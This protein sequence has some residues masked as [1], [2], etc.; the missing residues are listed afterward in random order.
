MTCL[1]DYRISLLHL[2]CL[3]WYVGS[4]PG[5]Q[6]DWNGIWSPGMYL[7]IWLAHLDLE[8]CILFI[9]SIQ[10][11]SSRCMDLLLWLSLP[12]HMYYS[13]KILAAAK[14][15]KPFFF[16]PN[17]VC[18]LVS[19]FG[20]NWS[21]TEVLLLTSKSY[22]LTICLNILQKEIWMLLLVKTQLKAA[23]R[24]IIIKFS[25]LLDQFFW[26]CS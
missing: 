8:L 15:T 26:L 17:N 7:K 25:P 12:L 5:E 24:V 1:S 9:P 2:F 22:I 14:H 4:A 23:K 13:P 6:P 10:V 16:P 11:L 21:M 3:K 18:R 20:I 19:I